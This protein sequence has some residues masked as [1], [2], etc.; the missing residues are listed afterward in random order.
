MIDWFICNVQFRIIYIISLSI[1]STESILQSESVDDVSE[2]YPVLPGPGAGAVGG[3]GVHPVQ[4]VAA[5]PDQSEVST[6]L[7]QSQLTS[8]AHQEA[9]EE[10][11]AV[12]AVV[13]GGGGGGRQQH[14]HHGHQRSPQPHPPDQCQYASCR[15]VVSKPPV[16][17]A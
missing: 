8:P 14:R 11:V 5:V 1:T 16:H 12:D 7:D 13:G 3:P 6:G 17:N 15:S 9:A 4:L 2:G 10:G